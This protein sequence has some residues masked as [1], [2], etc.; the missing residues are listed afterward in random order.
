MIFNFRTNH[1][2]EN[3]FSDMMETVKRLLYNSVYNYNQLASI[4]YVFGYIPFWIYLPKYIEIQYRKSASVA[5]FVTGFVGLVFAAIGILTAGI[6]VQKFKPKARY[7]AFWNM[8]ID[9][10]SLFGILSYSFLGCV[11]VD[12]QIPIFDNGK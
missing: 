7:M 6:I 8:I 3:K 11:P 5:S 12:E 9:L 4:F 2:H 1:I 10:I